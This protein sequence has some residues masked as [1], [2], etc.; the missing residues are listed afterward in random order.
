MKR[1]LAAFLL[2]LIP[3]GGTFAAQP[4]TELYGVPPQGEGVLDLSG[5]WRMSTLRILRA[6]VTA[7]DFDD[8]TWVEVPAP[9]SWEEQGVTPA[10]G[11][12]TVAVYRRTF[13]TLPDWQDQPVGIAAW[14]YPG[15][16]TVTL[17]GTRLEPEGEPPW[18]YA[19]VTALLSPSGEEN[20]IALSSQFDGRYEMTLPNPP[21]IGPLGSWSGPA[22]THSTT[23]V[24]VAEEAVEAFV[25]AP[26]GDGPYPGVLMIGTGSHGLAFIEPFAPLAVELA[27]NGYVSMAVALPAQSPENINVALAALRALPNVRADSLAVIAGTNSAT[28][29]LQAGIDRTGTRAIVAL[30]P[31]NA[32]LDPDLL[33]PTLFFAATQDATGPTSVYAQRA[34]EALGD[35]GKA[36]V[37]PGSQN[38]MAMLDSHWNPLRQGILDWLDEHLQGTR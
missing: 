13:Q 6:D 26:E 28:A 3:L 17:N 9:A 36:I 37:L 23:T 1:L 29:V 2:T 4:G 25:V 38:G 15:H 5:T 32:D 18:L 30:S 12:P 34:A 24:D 19:D 22:V 10:S 14:L 21:R 31:G 16:S 27:L 8:S 20:V 11:L 35:L 33:L 7:A